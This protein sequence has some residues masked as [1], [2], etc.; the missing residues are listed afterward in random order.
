MC[1]ESGYSKRWL[2]QI[3]FR[4]SQERQLNIETT[5]MAFLAGNADFSAMCGADGFHYGQA[6]SR[7]A[8]VARA[9]LIRPV[10]ALE[11]MGKGVRRYPSAIVR[12][13]EDR[14]TPASVNT[15]FDLAAF[16]C[17]F[18]GIR[19]EI[20][21]NLLK[22]RSIPLEEDTGSHIAHPLHQL[23]LIHNP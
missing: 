14:G 3:T 10:E 23:C 2:G 16:L 19:D 6:Q 21:D 8:G 1:S 5:A 11:D 18:G 22:A 15:H 13:L 12:D 7:P 9:C 4:D 17:V 20:H